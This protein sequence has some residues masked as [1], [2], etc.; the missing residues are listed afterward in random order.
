MADDVAAPGAGIHAVARAARV[1][2]RATVWARAWA[3][4]RSRSSRAGPFRT[5]RD[6]HRSSSP[7][8]NTSRS[9][10]RAPLKTL[11]AALAITVAM[12]G[13]VGSSRAA[14]LPAGG[15]IPRELNGTWSILAGDRTLPGNFQNP[16]GLTRSVPRRAR[17][18]ELA[19]RFSRRH[20]VLV[21]E[22]AA[23]RELRFDGPDL[24][25]VKSFDEGNEHVISACTFSKSCAPGPV[26]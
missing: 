14:N 18:G 5:K 25:S 2:A 3:A 4:V 24:P 11:A 10:R 22:D 6:S 7:R 13:I 19:R 15:P 16:T 23:Y 26:A 21:L 8:S 20:R 9:V 17:L 1:S 12:T